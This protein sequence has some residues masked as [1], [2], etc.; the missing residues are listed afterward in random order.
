M[1]SVS[2]VVA[3]EP[4]TPE[5]ER[6]W[7][8]IRDRLER[9]YPSWEI[10]THPGDGR[11]TFSKGSALNPAVASASGEVVILHDADVLM[12]PE[13][14]PDAVAA[15][16]PASWVI[17][18]GYVYRLNERATRRLIEGGEPGARDLVMA[19]FR[20]PAGGG[21]SVL[22][23]SD[24]VGIDEGFEGWGGEDI[25]F[26][27]AMDTLVGPHTR[28]D[29]PLRHLWHRPMVRRTRKRAS[30]ANEELANRY[31]AAN[32]DPEAMAALLEEARC[33]A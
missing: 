17:P 13:A 28:L 4:N 29:Y 16:L 33:L 26:A 1:S 6:N 21:I 12:A 10:I 23:R 24:Y 15:L 27:R 9:L 18:H 3:Y 25:S 20:G 22:R 2:V 8:F 19:P 31:L 5:R 11:A 30:F 32:G 14:L 7:T